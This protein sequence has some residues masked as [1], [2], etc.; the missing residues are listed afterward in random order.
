MDIVLKKT[1]DLSLDEIEQI[2]Y[3]FKNVFP[4]HNKSVNEFNNEFTNT[5]YGYSYHILLLSEG[6][7][8]GAQSYIPFKYFV[9]GKKTLFALS[10]D[11]MILEDYRNFDNIF[12]LWSIGRKA[13]KKEGVSFLF[14]FPNDNSY[15]LST[16]GFGDKDVGDL[17][18]YVLPYKVGS[19]FTKLKCF[20]K[21]LLREGY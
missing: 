14:G 1:S 18:T 2:C 8:V 13:I 20:K 10:V 3:V 17:V 19:Y 9:S 12:D 16:K 7:I 15:L 6:V 11:T 21:S 4:G 5:E